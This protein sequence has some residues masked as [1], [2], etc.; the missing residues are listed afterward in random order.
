MEATEELPQQ[1]RDAEQVMLSDA[2]VQGDAEEEIRGEPILAEGQG[3]T[4]LVCARI[5]RQSSAVSVPVL[6]CSRVHVLSSHRH[7]QTWRGSRY[8]H[9]QVIRWLKELI[10]LTSNAVCI[11]DLIAGLTLSCCGWFAGGGHTSS[12]GW[13]PAGA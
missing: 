8:D 10:H 9:E 7:R 5:G 2:V 13:Q 6:L 1:V 12:C 3:L 11:A 4:M